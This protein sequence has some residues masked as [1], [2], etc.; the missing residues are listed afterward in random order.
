MASTVF[1]VY[2]LVLHSAFFRESSPTSPLYS[3]GSSQG[4]LYS[5]KPGS[6]PR[7]AGWISV[8][9]LLSS[10]AQESSLKPQDQQPKKEPWCTSSISEERKAVFSGVRLPASNPHVLVISIFGDKS[11]ITS[12]SHTN[13]LLLPCPSPRTLRQAL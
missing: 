2:S 10:W 12:A 1:S 13:T 5:K 4:F 9:R 3:L 6:L 8:H 7:V 11:Q